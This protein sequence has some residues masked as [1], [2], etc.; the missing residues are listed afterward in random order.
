MSLNITL[1]V[2]DINRSEHFYRDLLSLRVERFV[3]AP[4]AEPVLLIDTDGATVVL[5]ASAVL[6]RQYPTIY[7][8]LEYH[9]HGVGVSIEFVV[10]SLDVCQRALER[11]GYSWL[12]KCEDH[13]HQMQELWLHDP[14]GYLVVLYCRDGDDSLLAV[15]R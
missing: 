8:D 11:G 14:D 1:A 5:C 7:R 2:A 4:G 15:S 3:A 13:E 12:H 9:P 6:Q 10:A